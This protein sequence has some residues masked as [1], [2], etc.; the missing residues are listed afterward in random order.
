MMFYKIRGHCTQAL[1]NT[2]PEKVKLRVQ[3]F[4]GGLYFR[5]HWHA[6]FTLG[7]VRLAQVKK[8]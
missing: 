8:W 7:I 2:L 1:R 3:C 5:V 6:P 4:E